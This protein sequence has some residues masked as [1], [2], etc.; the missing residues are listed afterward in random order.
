MSFVLDAFQ[1]VFGVFA[2][3]TYGVRPFLFLLYVCVLMSFGFLFFRFKKVL[4]VKTLSS[5]KI[6]RIIAF[7]A[8]FLLFFLNL[9]CQ[10]VVFDHH[11]IPQTALATFVDQSEITSTRLTHIHFGKAM[12]GAIVPRLSSKITAVADTGESLVAELPS[13][14]IV[15]QWILFLLA[16]TGSFFGYVSLS[17][18]VS[19]RG[20]KILLLILY[21]L[22]AFI[23][24]D[25]SVDGGL[26]SDG[27]F[28]ALTAYFALL[29]LPQHLFF[30][31]FLS[32]AIFYAW[33]T[34]G[35]YL[36]D[37]YWRVSYVL[38]ILEKAGL[39]FLLT[40][41]LHLGAYGNRK[42]L[43]IILLLAVAVGVGMKAEEKF[44][45][46]YSY[47]AVAI[48]PSHSYAALYGEGESALS[49]IGTVGRLNIYSFTADPE[50]TVG[51]FSRKYG[52]PPSYGPLSVNAEP[53][54]SAESVRTVKFFTLVERPLTKSVF[55][56]PNLIGGVFVPLGIDGRGWY[57][58]ATTLTLHECVP[59]TLD[60]ARESLREV[61]ATHGLIY[62][63]TLGIQKK[64]GT[65]PVA[66][67]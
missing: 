11:S 26:L 30:K 60:V 53:C 17:Q 34:A 23:V 32:G 67:K 45:L 65:V 31:A 22:T 18:S 25:K 12:L 8:V 36:L 1:S 39:F 58:Y 50:S 57:R 10:I 46:E 6:L 54:T 15:L 55:V 62:G 2:D 16:L 40:T 64:T 37:M 52:V 27:A 59:R 21:S 56:V 51:E 5:V 9:V 63:L 49:L 43:F 20:R 35:L 66:K 47:R 33:C 13:W 4:R 24:L 7:G 48:D 42:K 14:V 61:G 38:D 44:S 29:F 3:G 28:L 41:A 19:G